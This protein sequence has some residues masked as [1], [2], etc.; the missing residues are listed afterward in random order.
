MDGKQSYRSQVGIIGSSV[1][2]GVLTLAMGGASAPGDVLIAAE[3]TGVEAAVQ[4]NDPAVVTDPTMSSDTSL[5]DDGLFASGELLLFEKMPT[6]ISAARH[7][8]PINQLAV[9][10]SI[11][12]AQD[13]HYSGHT[14]IPEILRQVPGMD[15]L[16]TDRNNYA[17]GIRGL[18]HGMTDRTL[19]LQDGR[20]TGTGMLGATDFGRLP[21]F[22]ED[23][24]RIEVVR[25]PGGAAWGANAFNGVVNIITKEPE[26]VP[27]FLVTSTLNEFGDTYSQVRWGHRV[28]DLAWR[29]SM[30][31]ED[32][33]SSEGA[34]MRD[35][36]AANDH[37]RAIRFDG[38]GM[39]ESD[40]GHRLKFGLAG[41]DV[42]RGDQE[43]IGFPL[44]GDAGTNER[45]Q[46]L[47]SFVRWDHNHDKDETYYLQWYGNFTNE[48]RP[49]LWDAWSYENDVEF[50]YTNR[51]NEEHELAMG[52]NVRWTH[53]RSETRRPTDVLP[54]RTED[55]FWAGAFV[56]H[57]WNLTE[58]LTI[59]SQGRVDWYSAT[60]WDWSGRFSALYGLDEDKHHMLRGSVAKSFRAPLYVIRAGQGERVPL[61]TP[62]FPP[63]TFGITL[64][65]SV[66]LENEQIWSFET[67]YHGQLTDELTFAVDGYYQIY[68][69]LIGGTQLPSPPMTSISRLENIGDA[70]AFGVE[71]QLTWQV[72]NLQWSAWYAFNDVND[73]L[74]GQNM[75]SFRP[76]RHKV[77]FTGRWS[78][79][80]DLIANLTYRYTGLTPNDGVGA[81]TVAASV[82]VEDHHIFDVTFTARVPDMG[83]G[84]TFGVLDVFD[85][86]K[87]AIQQI[88]ALTSHATPGRTG[89]VRFTFNF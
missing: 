31:Y 25:G 32:F 21:L 42:V 86:S 63:D 53:I 62:P 43:F 60:Q 16:R 64:L 89:F 22:V 61:P 26:A 27:G 8:Q 80:D 56:I 71:T 77:G 81:T 10:V 2:L 45:L 4:S 5:S 84:I 54:T 48:D 9:P 6:V 67:G 36:F 44:P 74:E 78:I 82:P 35:N 30:G 46:T 7:S 33:E 51:L 73:E 66:G 79:T 38:V 29:L 47:R 37:A 28:D 49:S 17:V 20:S 52:G 87:L 58:Q 68:K 57:R 50:Q 3:A 59:E 14:N 72:D 15:V 40:P 19:V 70:T 23:I 34:I 12:T 83:M 69:D 55:E 11:I 24:E 76:A 75:R 1:G 13:I 18:H 88:G 65:P 39:L 41:S 85:E